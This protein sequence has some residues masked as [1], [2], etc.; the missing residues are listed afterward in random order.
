MT[1][2]RF[3]K[4]T[5]SIHLFLIVKII[6]FLPCPVLFEIRLTNWVFLLR[7]AVISRCIILYVVVSKHYFFCLFPLSLRS[8]IPYLAN[9]V[10]E[11][12][13][14]WF[15]IK[16]PHFDKDSILF[17]SRCLYSPIFK[18]LRA[19]SGDNRFHSNQILQ[20]LLDILRYQAI[21]D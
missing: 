20:Y 13:S 7:L 10:F 16:I 3:E 8:S 9:Q 18:L 11:L 2:Q 12:T 19:G 4:N 6:H 14:A 17:Y 5:Q 21:S 1:N 15:R